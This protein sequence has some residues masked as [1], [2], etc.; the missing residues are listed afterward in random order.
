MVTA[1]GH[2]DLAALPIE[3]R[4]K[5]LRRALGWTQVEMA[6]ELGINVRSVKRWEAGQ[7]PSEESAHEIA[8]LAPR[9]LNA[10][11]ELFFEPS[12]RREERLLELEK[13]LDAMER[14]LKRAGL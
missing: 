7:I 3:R 8:A 6:D 10:K 4:V 13:R 11:P 5:E 1:N 2:L 9:G 12:E 14:R